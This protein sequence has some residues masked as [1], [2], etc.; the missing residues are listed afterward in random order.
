MQIR[1][2][3]KSDIDEI[4]DFYSNEYDYEEYRRSK[5]SHA[6]VAEDANEIVGIYLA[7]EELLTCELVHLEVRE[8]LWGVGIGTEMLEHLERLC[9]KSIEAFIDER[10]VPMQAFLSRRGYTATNNIQTDDGEPGYLFRK[11]DR[12]NYAPDLMYRGVK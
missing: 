2:M 1:R 12:F 8:D 11:G 4:E 5:E 3:I 10:N 9:D 7:A 6:F